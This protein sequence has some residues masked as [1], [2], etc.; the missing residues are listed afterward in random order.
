VLII[1]IPLRRMTRKKHG[2]TR[3]AY[4]I[5]IGNPNGDLSVDGVVKLKGILS[6]VGYGIGIGSIW[7]SI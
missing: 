2:V 1:I 3:I 4:V 6:K 7:L 5:L